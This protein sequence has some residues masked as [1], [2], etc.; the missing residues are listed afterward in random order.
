MMDGDRSILDLNVDAAALQKVFRDEALVG[1][2][3]QFCAPPPS[4]DEEELESLPCS[5]GHT[6]CYVSPYGDVYPCVQFPLPSGNVRKHAFLDIWRHS[7]QLN[8]V[9]SI[10]IARSA[11][12]LEVHACLVV[13]ALPWPGVHGRQYARAVDSGL[14]KIIRAHGDS[15]GQSS[16]EEAIHGGAGADSRS[17]RGGSSS[18][19]V[20]VDSFPRG[21]R[22]ELIRRLIRTGKR[23]M[24]F[25]RN[26]GRAAARPKIRPRHTPCVGS[27]CC[28]SRTPVPSSS[29]SSSV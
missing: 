15:V 19:G 13:H 3:E 29:R 25:A 8:E 6:A 26:S 27:Y 1:N 24:Y 20:R 22:I 4:A 9:R 12:L 11:E 18:R 28:C 21:I 16:F 2:V 14:R 23:G 10:R 17:T 5:A 7:D